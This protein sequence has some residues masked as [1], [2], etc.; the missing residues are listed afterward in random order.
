MILFCAQGFDF[1]HGFTVCGI[2]Q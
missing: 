1:A 2:F